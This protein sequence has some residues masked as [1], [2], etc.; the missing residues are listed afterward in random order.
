M[1]AVAMGWLCAQF[2]LEEGQRRVAFA[3]HRKLLRFPSPSH[4]MAVGSRTH[5]DK[6]LL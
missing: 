4:P 1:A 5:V 3:Q 2:S 6:A